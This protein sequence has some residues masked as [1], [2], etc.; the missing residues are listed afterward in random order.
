MNFDGSIDCSK[1]TRSSNCDIVSRG[2]DVNV[3]AYDDI[4]LKTR[5][6]GGYIY[7]SVYGAARGFETS[8]YFGSYSHKVWDLGNSTSHAWDEVYYDNLH[9]VG[10]TFLNINPSQVYND[11][12]KMKFEAAH[13]KLPNAKKTSGLPELHLSKFP[14]YILDREAYILQWERK[15]KKAVAERLKKRDKELKIEQKSDEEYLQ[16]VEKI[17]LKSKIPSEYKDIFEIHPSHRHPQ[18]L[19]VNPGNWLTA[20]TMAFQVAQKKIA[21]LEEEI[22]LLKE[23]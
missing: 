7:H 21:E 12:L 20:L 23:S 13:P 18:E 15:N 6:S 8:S 19:G 5:S 4:Y 22:R 14:D 3:D 1:I 17:T 9:N 2:A 16:M 11:F 10:P